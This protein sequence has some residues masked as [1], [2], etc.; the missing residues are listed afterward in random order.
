MY[1][2]VTVNSDDD[3][4]PLLQTLRQALG[5]A[6]SSDEGLPNTKQQCID[7]EKTNNKHKP[8][9]KPVRKLKNA[10]AKSSQTC[11]PKAQGSLD[12][13]QQQRVNEEML[14]MQ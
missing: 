12:Y 7:Y 2:S 5:H 14:K 8:S 1:S 3:D 10:T 4:D 6:I 9:Y 11:K 13:K